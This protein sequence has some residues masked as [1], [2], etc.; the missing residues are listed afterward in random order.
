MAAPAFPWVVPAVR[1]L[2]LEDT[3]FA[4]LC[5]G[6]VS[7]RLPALVPGPS[8][9]LSATAIPINVPAG[10]WSPLVQV[11]AFV[12]PTSD[13]SDP[14]EVAWKVVAMAAGL[15]STVRNRPFENMH[16]SARITDGPLSD[17]DVSRGEGNP[18]YRGI[19]RA[20]LI[21]HAR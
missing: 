16:F 6:R 13:G 19:I 10:V 2:L 9:R 3:S 5:G 8:V 18:L 7:T 20:E 21:V 15:L 17:F 14:E 12:P 4:A 1:E 11:D